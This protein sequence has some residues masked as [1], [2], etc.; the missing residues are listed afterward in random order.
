MTTFFMLI[1]YIL[2][3][4]LGMLFYLL[5]NRVE[6]LATKLNQSVQWQIILRDNQDVLQNDFKRLFN[7]FQNIKKEVNQK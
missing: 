6:N 3:I 1:A 4:G 7:E 5:H 2:L